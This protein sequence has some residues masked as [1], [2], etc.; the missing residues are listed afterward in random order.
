MSV[1]TL[2]G[3]YLIREA[4][5]IA[6]VSI[7]TLRTEIREG[8]LPVRRIGRCVRILDS[9]LEAWMRGQ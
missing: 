8:R 4:A 3:F 9:D 7:S 6:K 5:G 2:P 1:S